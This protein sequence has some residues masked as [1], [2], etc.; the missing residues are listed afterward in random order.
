MSDEQIDRVISTANLCRFGRDETLIEQGAEGNSM[1]ILMTGVAD[2]YVTSNGGERTPVAVLAAG[3]YFGEMSLLTGEKRSA[4]VV[5]QVDC[6]VLEVGK[7]QFARIVQDNPSLLENL[8][9][10]LTRRRLEVEGV[11]ASAAGDKALSSKQQE[12]KAG[13]LAKMFSIFEL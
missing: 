12:Y 10:L 3:D 8:S 4:T 11:L 2:V 13:F 1:F 7:E 6:D 9:E 5:A